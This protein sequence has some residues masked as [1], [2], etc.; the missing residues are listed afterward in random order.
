MEYLENHNA[1]PKP[2]IWTKSA[3]QILEKVARAKTSVRVTTLVV[4]SFGL[5]LTMNPPPSAVWMRGSVA[6]CFT[7]F[8]E[9]PNNIN[10]R[11]HPTPSANLIELN[12]VFSDR[13]T[14][15]CTIARRADDRAPFVIALLLGALMLTTGPGPKPM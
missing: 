5:R 7:I 3:S 1:D 9:R 6:N 15:K 2:F 4:V 13:R 10:V 8:R 11:S 14:N 12:L